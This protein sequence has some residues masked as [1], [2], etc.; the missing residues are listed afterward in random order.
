MEASLLPFY[1]TNVHS[2]GTKESSTRSVRS[3]FSP[4]RTNSSILPLCLSWRIPLRE[5]LSGESFISRYQSSAAPLFP[6]LQCEGSPT[7]METEPIARGCRAEL[8]HLPRQPC[9]HPH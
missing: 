7:R 4:D 8:A 5:I 6:G 3:P 2:K 1:G 9:D